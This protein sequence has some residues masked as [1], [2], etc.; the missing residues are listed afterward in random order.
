MPVGPKD[1]RRQ[2]GIIRLSYPALMEMIKQNYQVPEDFQIETMRDMRDNPG[3]QFKEL[4][5]RG[6]SKTYPEHQ[7]GTPIQKY[8]YLNKTPEQPGS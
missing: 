4:Q 8:D 5:I 6:T 1:I 3:F 7:A 2:L